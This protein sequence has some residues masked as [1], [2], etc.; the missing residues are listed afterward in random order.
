M[1]KRGKRIPEDIS[2]ISVGDKWYGSLFLQQLTAITVD[3][4][5]TGKL[6]AKLLLEMRRGKRA[7]D[8]KEQFTMQLELNVGATV[9]AGPNGRE[10]RIT[11]H[12]RSSDK[13]RSKREQACGEQPQVVD[14]V[15]S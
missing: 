13:L 2:L 10:S 12:G 15:H 8:S 7:I 14:S 1:R 5:A 3:G 4:E 9:R 11:A 6:A